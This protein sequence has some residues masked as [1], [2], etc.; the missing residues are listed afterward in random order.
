M[1]GGAP[2]FDIDKDY[3]FLQV[4]EVDRPYNRQRDRDYEDSSN[5]LVEVVAYQRVVGLNLICYGRNSFD[6]VV[7]LRD[8]MFQRDIREALARENIFYV[9]NTISPRRLE[10]NFQGQW[11]SRSDIQFLFNELIERETVPD[12]VHDIRSSE[13]GIWENDKGLVSQFEVT[14]PDDKV[15]PKVP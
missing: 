10:E 2:A 8:G 3:V 13:V 12:A 11:W 6:N 1:S 7:F 14:S 4:S 9:P 15:H 5:G